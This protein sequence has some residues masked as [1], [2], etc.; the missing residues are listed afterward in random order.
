M[1][2]FLVACPF[3]LPMLVFLSVPRSDVVILEET[4]NFGDG[5][6]ETSVAR[7]A[8]SVLHWNH[9]DDKVLLTWSE[10]TDI[11]MTLLVAHSYGSDKSMPAPLYAPSVY[12]SARALLDCL[13][14]VFKK[15]NHEETFAQLLMLMVNIRN[16]GDASSI[17]TLYFNTMCLLQYNLTHRTGNWLLTVKSRESG[18]LTVVN[19]SLA[20]TVDDVRQQ[21]RSSIRTTG[22]APPLSSITKKG[23]RAQRARRVY[24]GC[25]C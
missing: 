19:N 8:A 14:A 3:H 20:I 25:R 1:A 4:E 17:E 11:R 2:K 15:T 23:S 12:V 16:N 18:L 10:E 6:R 21:E 24:H 9:F 5:V 13:L 7:A 22:T